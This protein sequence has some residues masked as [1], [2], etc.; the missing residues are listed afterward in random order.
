MKANIGDRLVVHGAHVDDPWR[1]GE[2]LE[3]HGPD[4]APGDD[5]ARRLSTMPAE[6]ARASSPTDSTSAHPGASPTPAMLLG[7]SG[8][9]PRP[10][11][12]STEMA[13]TPRARVSPTDTTE[14]MSAVWKSSAIVVS[15]RV[16]MRVRR[17]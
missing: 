10:H 9:M 3:V 17:W 16:R 7:S 8:H 13:M 6:M 11:S 12:G 2:I 4:V 5:G 14:P 1:A 15:V